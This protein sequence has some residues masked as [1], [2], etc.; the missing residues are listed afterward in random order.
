MPPRNKPRKTD[1]TATNQPQ[2]ATANASTSNQQ[3]S[4]NATRSTGAGKDS[5]SRDNSNFAGAGAAHKPPH[6]HPDQ[7]PRRKPSRK[8]KRE[9][10]RRAGSG[11]GA[12]MRREASR[13]PRGEQDRR[14]NGS[15]DDGREPPSFWRRDRMI[16]G[17]AGYERGQEALL[18]SARRLGRRSEG[19]IRGR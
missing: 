5:V 15:V 8:K 18:L 6:Y 11:A 10:N 4:E 17:A 14:A 2:D 12:S 7:Q 3:A 1:S 16:N 13:N 19:V 9:F